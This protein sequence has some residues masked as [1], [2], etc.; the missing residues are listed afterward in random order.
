MTCIRCDIRRLGTSDNERKVHARC[1]KAQQII[2]A[3]SH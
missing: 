2:S 3:D 1:E